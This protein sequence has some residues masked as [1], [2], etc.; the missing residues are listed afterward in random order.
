MRLLMLCREPRLYSCV[1]L[2]E[3][4]IESGHQIDILD[5]NRCIL[6]LVYHSQPKLYYQAANEPFYQ[7]LPHYDGIIPRFGTASTEMGCRV[8]RYF[9]QR[10]IPILNQADAFALA[11]DKWQ[12]LQVLHQHHLPVPTTSFGGCEV[13]ATAIADNI[14]APAILKTLAGSQGIG[15]M[16]M[17]ENNSTISVLETLKHANI[18]V[19]AQQFI[20]EAKGDDLR[21]FVIG[22]RVVSAMERQGKLGEFRANF[23]RGG[24]AIP[25]E[26][27][28]EEREL[29]TKATQLI[30]LDVAGV[31]II[32]TKQGPMILEVN[33]SPG[34]EL[35]EKTSKLDIALQMI[36]YLERKIADKHTHLAN[37][38]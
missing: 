31:D 2:Q 3:A 32:R 15:V 29:A 1:R 12:S 38:T 14:G 30:G 24:S 34:L 23:H 18:P 22:Q 11:R 16:L 33:A 8:L 21:C 5:P 35:I 9:E 7:E 10:N 4:A 20:S 27:T 26:L 13:N 28:N 36:A 19:L 25:A 6:Q 37:N 17:P